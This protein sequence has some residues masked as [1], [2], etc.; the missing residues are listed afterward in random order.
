MSLIGQHIRGYEILRQI[1]SG[2]QSV[3]Y[4]AH[5]AEKGRDVAI[6][7]MLPEFLDDPELL[8]R[9]QYEA[10]ISFRLKHPHIVPLYDY[11]RDEHG[12]WLVM[13]YLPG[14]SL[15]AQF[16]NG[17][18]SL[19]RT[20]HMLDDIADALNLAHKNNIIHRD[21]K[22]DNILFDAEQ[23]AYLTDFGVAKRL[24]ADP[25]TR[26]EMMVGSPAYLSPE[27]IRREEVTPRTD[28]YILGI[29]L[30]ET[31]T[32]RHPFIEAQTKM[33][34][35]LKHLREPLPPLSR[36]RPDLP[37]AVE[38]VIQKAT[39]KRPQDRYSDASALIAAF[40]KAVADE[41]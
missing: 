36:A 12:A 17:P 24:K 8:A 26:M 41:S 11:W 20:A 9:F 13:R 30:Y 2:G 16:A 39:A 4:L 25:I 1:G 7:V 38:S 29:T 34:I 19:L 6:K 27:Q 31:L 37:P 33:Q 21:L 3:V 40:W 5:Q 22:P 15:R 35:L 18:W 32:G 28:I 10:V 14:G 23:R